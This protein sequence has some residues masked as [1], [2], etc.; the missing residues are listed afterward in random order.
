[1]AKDQGKKKIVVQLGRNRQQGLVY[2]RFWRV[3][4]LTGL[5]RRTTFSIKAFWD[6]T[7]LL[8]SQRLLRC[9][10]SARLTRLVVMA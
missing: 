4:T 10:P 9:C 2:A 7:I 6:L 8:E 5:E 1:M 3:L